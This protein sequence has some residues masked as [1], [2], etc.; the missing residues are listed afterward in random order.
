VRFL[1]YSG[2]RV[3]EA[4][5][6][7]WGDLQERPDGD[8]QMSVLGKGRKRRTLPLPRRLI[9]P[10]VLELRPAG[11]TSAQVIFEFGPRR[12]Q[13]I[14]AELSVLAGLEFKASP[15]WLRHAAASHALDRGAPVHVVQQSLGHA[16][17]ATTTRYSH[18]R[19][20]GAS[21]YLSPL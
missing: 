7:R 20:D 15:H 13:A 10:L 8:Y 17:L 16:S 11:V 12:A 3:A 2:C 1:Y 18:K 5:G 21:R 14:V 9:E 4:V 6:V 19:G